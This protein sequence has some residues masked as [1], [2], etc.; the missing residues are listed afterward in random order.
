MGRPVI[1]VLSSFDHPPEEEVTV[2]TSPLCPELKN[3]DQ[4]EQKQ[5]GP[6]GESNRTALGHHLWRQLSMDDLLEAIMAHP[7]RHPI[8]DTVD[9][10][11]PF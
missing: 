1:L 2:C 10:P 8:D 7:E 4:F 9:F 3:W 6:Y 11:E 5:E